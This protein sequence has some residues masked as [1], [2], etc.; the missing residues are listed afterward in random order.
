MSDNKKYQLYRQMMQGYRLGPDGTALFEHAVKCWLDMNPDNPFP[1][2]SDAFENFFRVKNYYNVWKL[3]GP[4]KKISMRRMLNAAKDLCALKAK[5]P[6]KYDKQAAEEEKVAVK[7]NAAKAHEEYLKSVQEAERQKAEHEEE[8]RQIMKELNGDNVENQERVDS[9][10]AAVKEVE[11]KFNNEK[12]F[13]EVVKHYVFNALEKSENELDV[14]ETVDP[15]SKEKA[16][17]KGWL[18][19]LLK[20]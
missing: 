16:E 14:T 11:T 8:V 1:E 19:R 10:K 15:E 6:Y 9:I 4:D 12:P 3:G 20:R 5:N 17:K 18:H 2:G 7:E 13:Y